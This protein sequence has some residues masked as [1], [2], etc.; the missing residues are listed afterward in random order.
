MLTSLGELNMK[1]KNYRVIRGMA[2]TKKKFI[3]GSPPPKISKFTMGNTSGNFAYRALL[4][5]LNNV[6][7]RHNALEA[8]RI[9]VNKVLFDKLG[10]AGYRLKVVVY[11]HHILRENKMMAFAGADRLQ[12][13]MR[14]SFGKPVGAAAR[15]RTGQALI[16]VCVNENGTETAKEALQHG[17][18][19]LPTKCQIMIEE[20]AK[21]AA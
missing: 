6:Q 8:A 13:G 11:P 10:E 3:H 7:I 9:A 15:V 12:E 16:E 5:S 1:G 19:K 14:R 4:I 18:S 17:A 2:Y 20:S 21:T